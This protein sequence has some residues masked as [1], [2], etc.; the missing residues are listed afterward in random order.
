[1]GLSC[2]EIYSS[3]GYLVVS[4]LILV[5]GYTRHDYLVVSLLIIAALL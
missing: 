5:I 2:Y 4:L 1:M 3:W